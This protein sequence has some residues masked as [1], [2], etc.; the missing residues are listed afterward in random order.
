MCARFSLT[1]SEQVAKYF[2]GRLTFDEPS[3]YNIAPSDSALSVVAENNS[4]IRIEPQR[5]GLHLSHRPQP[6]INLRSEGRTI[7]QSF[8]AQPRF[9]RCLIPATG[10]FEWRTE[11]GVKQPYNFVMADDDAF[12]FAALCQAAPN[13]PPEFAILTCEPNSLVAQYHDRMPSIIESDSADAWLSS[14]VYEDIVG[15]AQNPLPAERMVAYAVTRK[16]GSPRY[17]SA[18]CIQPSEPENPSLF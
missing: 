7:D 10:F 12:A 16:M 13:G 6:V 14:D 17:Q 1:S 2:Q 5:W 11:N 8:G 18:D 9:Q 15:L 4:E 3:R